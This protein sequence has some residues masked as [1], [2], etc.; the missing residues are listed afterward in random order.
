MSVG[1]Q[2]GRVV[3]VIEIV[4]PGNKSSTAAFRT[5]VEKTS[6]L[7]EEGVHALIIDLFPPTPSDP[8][9]I[10]RAIW[11]EFDDE[12]HASRPDKSLTVASYDAG[13]IKTAYVEP[14]AVGDSLPDMPLFLEPGYYVNVPLEAT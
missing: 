3:A 10:H 13:L 9:G 6:H 5:I 8:E 4:S 1:H 2:S 12:A 14:I 11:D 7:I